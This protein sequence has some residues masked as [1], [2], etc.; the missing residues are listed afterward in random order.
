MLMVRSRRCRLG[1]IRN[2]FTSSREA[3]YNARFRQVL[4]DYCNAAEFELA[5]RW[6]LWPL[7]IVPISSQIARSDLDALLPKVARPVSC[8]LSLLLGVTTEH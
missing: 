1:S 4:I 2:S 7:S 5:E 8:F 3:D 6:D